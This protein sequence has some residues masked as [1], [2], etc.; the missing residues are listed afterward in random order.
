M[1]RRLKRTPDLEVALTLK[2][3]DFLAPPRDAQRNWLLNRALGEFATDLVRLDE[4]ARRFVPGSPTGAP[5]DRSTRPLR[6]EEIM[7]DWQLPIMKAM[8]R[9]VTTEPGD[10]LE[11]GFGRG[12][13]AAYLQ[14]LGVRSHTI[15]ECNDV[16]ARDFE[17]W[18]A[19]YPDRDIRFI[20]ARWQDAVDQLGPFDGVF[21]HTYPLDEAEFVSQVVESTTFAAHF[22]PHAAALLREGGSF[23][24]MTN[25]IDSLGREHQRLLLQHFDSVT[26]RVLRDLALPPDLQDAWWADSMVVVRAVR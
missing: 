13:S 26:V 23:T 1:L 19:A 14:E 12:V 16:I 6:P 8:A 9:E 11:I 10:V 4:A 5:E 18:R 22:F 25:E 24:Y 21:F 2:R 20:H 15:I 17:S 7:E 3:D